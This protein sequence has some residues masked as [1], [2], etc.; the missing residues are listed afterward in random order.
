[1]KLL[2][3]LFSI[4]FLCSLKTGPETKFKVE[5]TLSDWNLVYSNLNRVENYL[6][7]TNLPHQDLKRVSGYLEQVK[8]DMVSQL[9]PQLR[10]QAHLDSLAAA[11]TKKP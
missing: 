4:L 2:I 5:H 6:D 9:G 8:A 3:A 7:S 1:M 11:K 10:E